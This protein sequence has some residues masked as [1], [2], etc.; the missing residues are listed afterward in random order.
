[1]EIL[2]QEIVK[3]LAEGAIAPGK[4][5]NA[6]DGIPQGWD[7][8]QDDVLDALRRREGAL[9]VECLWRIHQNEIQTPNEDRRGL[10]TRDI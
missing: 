1:M 2:H 4:I 10:V 9:I 3:L 7:V 5:R 6:L 8:S